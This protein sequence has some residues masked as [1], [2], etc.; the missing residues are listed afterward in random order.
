MNHSN[1]DTKTS[2]HT[3]PRRVLLAVAGLSPQILTET[4]HALAVTAD[5]PWIP[6]DIR[7]LTTAEGAERARLSLLSADPG[8]YARLL[9]DYALPAIPFDS[10][11]IRILTDAHGH[12]L[13]DIRNLADNTQVADQIT[14]A[15][16]ALTAD[17]DCALHVSLAGGRKTM[18]YFT[19]AMRCPCLVARK[20]V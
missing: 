11:H 20:I 14:E 16:R 6:T 18:G 8:W 13:P 1:Q 9:S 3:Y 5:P 10:D 12:P 7:L 2:P 17:P 15:I 19:P 4:L